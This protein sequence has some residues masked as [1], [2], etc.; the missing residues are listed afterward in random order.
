[1]KVLAA[2]VALA[3]IAVAISSASDAKRYAKMR[4]M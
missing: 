1:M 3:I 4:K 2:I